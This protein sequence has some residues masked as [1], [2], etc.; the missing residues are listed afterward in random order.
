MDD[1]IEKNEMGRAYSTY[2][3]EVHTGFWWGDLW[4]RYNLEDPDVE[5]RII[6]KLIFRKWDGEGRGLD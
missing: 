4:V 5:G 1:Q 3:G 2:G 6:V